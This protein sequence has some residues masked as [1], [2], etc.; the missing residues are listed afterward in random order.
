MDLEQGNLKFSIIVPVYN[1]EDYLK[2]CI[3]SILL[4]SYSNYELIL[5]DDGSSDSSGLMCDRIEKNNK[6]VRVI[7]KKNGGLSSARN[8]GLDIAA[9]EYVMFI[10]SDDFLAD[11][12]ALESIDKKIN[13]THAD[14]VIFSMRKYYTEINTYEDIVIRDID[15]NCIENEGYY[16][17]ISYMIEHNIYKASACN[18][19]VKKSI[20]NA[21]RIRFIE[22]Y[23]NEDIDWC[24]KLLLKTE[25]FAYLDRSI[26]IYRQQRSGSIT[27]CVKDMNLMEDRLSL[28][29]KGYNEALMQDNQ[30]KKYLLASYYAYEYAVLLG[31]STGASPETVLQMKQIKDIMKYNLS[32]KVRLVENVSRVLGFDFTRILMCIFVNLKNRKR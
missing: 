3:E 25:K 16:K 19:V 20:I 31:T 14:L 27:S 1:V 28:C 15:C 17:A 2:E 9:G 26:Y 13:T 30:K 5:V 21:T 23:L 32:K 22:G 24:G 7:H 4:Q 18:K 8:V 10:D 6:N 11:D 12:S 29:R